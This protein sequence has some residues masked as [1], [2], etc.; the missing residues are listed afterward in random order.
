MTCIRVCF[1]DTFS[2]P[3]HKYSYDVFNRVKYSYADDILILRDSTGYTFFCMTVNESPY[4]SYCK[5]K[6][7]PSNSLYFPIMTENKKFGALS[8]NNNSNVF[9]LQPHP[10]GCK[11]CLWKLNKKLP[12]GS[13]TK[14]ISGQ[15][16]Q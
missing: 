1:Y 6:I 8:I 10:Q 16:N 12:Q 13:L 15:I 11:L 5:P 14:C 3:F 2:L 9:S 4:F 7:S